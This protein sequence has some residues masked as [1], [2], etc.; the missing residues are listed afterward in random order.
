MKLFYN[1]VS[2]SILDVKPDKRNEC[3]NFGADNAFPSV[4]EALVSMSVTSKTCHDRVSKAIYGKSFGEQGKVIVNSKGQ[5]LNEVLRIA[6]REYAKHNNCYLHVNYTLDSK[7]NSIV[8]LPVTEV[9]IGKADD[10][11]YSGKFIVY[12]NWD[13]SKGSRIIATKFKLI[14]KYN[15]K[16]EVVK[17]QIEKAWN[18]DNYNGQIL[19]IRKDSSYIYS[20]T[21]LYPALSEALLESNS[22]TFR[23][24]GAEKGFLNTKLLVV[25][26]FKDNDERKS[27]RKE[28]NEVRGANNSSEVVLLE[29]SQV[30]DDLTKQINL[31]DLSGEYNDG[32]FKYSD[33]QAEK[34]ICKAFVVPLILVSQT[35]NSMF[36]SS[37]DL[38]QEAKIQLWESREEDRDQFEEVFTDLIKKF[39]KPIE[40]ILKVKNPFIDEDEEKQAKNLNKQSQAALRGSVG[41]VTAITSLLTNVNEG[42]IGRGEAVAVVRNI[43]GFTAKQAKEMVG[44][45]DE[46]GNLIE[47]N[48][49]E[50]QNNE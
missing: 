12:D 16:E 35:D 32:L 17:K 25:Q 50:N 24:K 7:I 11:G 23:S 21:D 10:K 34:N 2:S 15:P 8:V 1:Q 14:D 26:P 42:L 43:Y 40:A 22:Q 18:I 31:T 20:Y 9:R 36:G 4:V 29:A 19:H 37:G 39:K 6:V 46:D 28:L 30:S 13:K 44:G 27:F 45:F 5:S 38:L 48:K 47:I 33:T 41:G 3:F 49:E